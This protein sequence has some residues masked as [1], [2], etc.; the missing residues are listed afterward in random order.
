MGYTARIVWDFVYVNSVLFYVVL[1]FCP[2]QAN[3]NKVFSCN[4][5]FLF[6]LCLAKLS[7]CDDFYFFFELAFFVNMSIYSAYPAKL[8]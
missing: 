6:L 2:A 4:F 7:Q 5:W 1:F 3:W 8:S